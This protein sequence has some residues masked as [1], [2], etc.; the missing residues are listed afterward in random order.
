MSYPWFSSW[1]GFWV[2]VPLDFGEA[3]RLGMGDGVG[4][5]VDMAS[6]VGRGLGD[7]SEK[8]RVMWCWGTYG[9]L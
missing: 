2:S 6:G 7:W 5:A 4:S 3:G 9:Y 1:R 8:T